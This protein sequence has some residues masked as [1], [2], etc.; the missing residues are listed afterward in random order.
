MGYFANFEDVDKSYEGSIP[1]EMRVYVETKIDEAET[2][3]RTLVPRLQE[4]FHLPEIDQANARRVVCAAV[5][6]VFRNPVGLQSQ[7][8]GP[9]S[10][11][12]FEDNATGLLTFTD[13]DLAVFRT[14]RRS[15]VGMVGVARPWFT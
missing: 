12:L 13:E 6:R 15:R 8:S 1:E 2:L 7:T 9:W 3:L 4:S 5:L 10:Q 14:R 11:T